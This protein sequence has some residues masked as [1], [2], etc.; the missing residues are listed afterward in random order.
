MMRD[1]TTNMCK[2]PCSDAKYGR[3][4]HTCSKDNPRLF[5]DVIRGSEQWNLTYKRRTTVE[6][7]NKREKVDY[8]L[9]TGRHRSTMMWYIRIYG[10]MMCQ[11]I[12]AW[13][14]HQ[15]ETLKALEEKILPQTA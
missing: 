1:R 4:Y 2:T 15:R 9:E 5:T 8:K 7:S 14:S 12:D 6:R 13:Y 11:H 3:T 10:I